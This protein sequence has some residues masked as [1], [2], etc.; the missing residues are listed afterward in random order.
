MAFPRRFSEKERV[1]LR[2]VLSDEERRRSAE[3]LR[4]SDGQAFIV[5][6]AMLRHL[7]SAFTR[8]DPAAWRFERDSGGRPVLAP[9]DNDSRLQFSLSHL[10]DRVAVAVCRQGAVGVDLVVPPGVAEIPGTALSKS[11][12][13]LLS[14]CTDES[15]VSAFAGVFAVKEAA[16]KCVGSGFSVDPA[17]LTALVSGDGEARVLHGN[18]DLPGVSRVRVGEADGVWMAVAVETDCLPHDDWNSYGLWRGP[19]QGE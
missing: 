11:E 6:H 8:R 1:A 9:S 15:S 5:A 14:A 2:A 17:A 18:V 13:R 16:L 10:V 7:L 12:Q 19:A 4:P 3:L